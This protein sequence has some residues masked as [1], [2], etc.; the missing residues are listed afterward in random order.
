MNYYSHVFWQECTRKAQEVRDQSSQKLIDQELQ[1]TKVDITEAV[2][3]L[4]RRIEDKVEQAINLGQT[5]VVL[6]HLNCSQ[7]HLWESGNVKGK[8]YDGIRE[9]LA[10]YLCL[11][12]DR[13]SKGREE[14][15]SI[16]FSF[17]D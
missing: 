9:T 1:R 5:Q 8:S 4:V 15:V 16:N 13:V 10:G 3:F 2:D 11:P 14:Q 17:N 12:L 6:G 7:A